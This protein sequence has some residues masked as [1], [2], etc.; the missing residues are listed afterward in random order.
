MKMTIK[1]TL[2]LAILL[3]RLTISVEGGYHFGDIIKFD[4]TGFNHYAIWVG[5][6]VFGEVF[7]TV[8]K[9]AFD[10]LD[11]VKGSSSPVV[12]NDLDGQKDVRTVVQMIQDIVTLNNDC[13]RYHV[14]KNNCEHI[15]TTIRYGEAVFAETLKKNQK[16]GRGRRGLGLLQDETRANQGAPAA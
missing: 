1:Q 11:V 3:F 15:A 10:S 8:T 16:R 6:E 14:G 5:D 2:T 9:C 12:A 4:R 7:S 13:G